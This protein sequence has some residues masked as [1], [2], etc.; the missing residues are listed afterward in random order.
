M[1]AV[2]QITVNPVNSSIPNS[3]D[4][5]V[6][7]GRGVPWKHTRLHSSPQHAWRKRHKLQETQWRRFPLTPT[8]CL[9][10]V[11]K[12]SKNVCL[13]SFEQ[14]EEQ[15]HH[16]RQ[17]TQWLLLSLTLTSWPNKNPKSRENPRL[18]L[19]S[20]EGCATYRV[21]LA[22]ASDSSW[23]QHSRPHSETQGRELCLVTMQE[24]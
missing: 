4:S 13:F 2:S 23:R 16:M 8:S 11:R 14:Q 22:E 10:N 21:L 3:P 18:L 20:H 19:T 12:W 17:L 7:K 24:H 15:E 1:K 5:C 6:N 9:N